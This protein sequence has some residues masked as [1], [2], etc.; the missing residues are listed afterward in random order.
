MKIFTSFA[1][2]K[3]LHTVRR[4]LQTEGESFETTILARRR[5][6]RDGDTCTC[7]LFAQLTR[8]TGTALGFAGFLGGSPVIQASWCNLEEK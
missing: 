4:T 5:C 3:S 6:F 1:R 7:E 8:G 2:V